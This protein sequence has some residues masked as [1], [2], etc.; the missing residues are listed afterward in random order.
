M[1]D[2]LTK[3]LSK[4]EVVQLCLSNLSVFLFGYVFFF[5]PRLPFDWRLKEANSNGQPPF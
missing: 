5:F 4:F 3:E 2:H 1:D